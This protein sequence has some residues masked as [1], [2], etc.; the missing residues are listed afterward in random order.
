MISTRS[1]WVTEPIRTTAELKSIQ[2]TI[3]TNN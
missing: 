3:L 2:Y 1:R